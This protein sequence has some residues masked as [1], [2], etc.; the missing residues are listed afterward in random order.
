MSEEAM[1]KARS[2]LELDSVR[3][4]TGKAECN[5]QEIN[6]K[7]GVVSRAGRVSEVMKR[8]AEGNSEQV[9]KKSR[10]LQPSPSSGFA[11]LRGSDDPANVNM[12]VGALN[13]GRRIDYV[14][15]K[16]PLASLSE[17]ASAMASHVGYWLKS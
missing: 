13:E 5:Y 17:Y 3:N 4:F 14:L 9:V 10:V 6:D 11:E 12:Q 2:I 8:P 16:G 1:T 15:Q 7:G